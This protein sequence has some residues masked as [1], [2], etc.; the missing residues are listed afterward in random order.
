MLSQNT[1]CHDKIKN[2]EM[3]KQLGVVLSQ[4]VIT[5][6]C[7]GI[8]G[9]LQPDESHTGPVVCIEVVSRRKINQ[10]KKTTQSNVMYCNAINELVLLSDTLKDPRLWH[11]YVPR[12]V[13]AA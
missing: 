8:H 12:M 1:F 5:G 11:S 7:N 4:V 13:V 10:K 6:S 9:M 2:N 3:H